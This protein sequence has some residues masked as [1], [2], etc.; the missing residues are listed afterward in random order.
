M[1]KEFDVELNTLKAWLAAGIW[2][3]TADQRLRE[4]LETQ[5]A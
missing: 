1:E 4:L 5:E 2:D 3:E